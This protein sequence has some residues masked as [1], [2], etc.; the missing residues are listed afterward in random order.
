MNR[1]MSAVV[2]GL[3]LACIAGGPAEA[4]TASGGEYHAEAVSIGAPAPV[5]SLDAVVGQEFK[6]ISLAD[7]R[8]KWVV[9]FFYPNDFTFVCPTEIK[10]FNAALDEFGKRNAVVLG[11]SADS[12]YSHL[13]WIKRG[14]L[15]DLKFPLLSDF[16]KE[17]AGRY[18]VLNRQDGAARRGLFIIDPKGTLQYVLIHNDD[19]GRSIEETLRVVD[20]LQT[21]SLCPLGWKPGQKTISR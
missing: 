8:G 3:A 13:A 7:Y 16:T 20:A 11:V 9:L 10:G 17:T 5:F 19:V 18:G 4:G 21:G 6:R 2:L 1:L 15:G 14:D 12:K